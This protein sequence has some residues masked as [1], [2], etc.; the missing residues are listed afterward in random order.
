[1]SP[2]LT[3]THRNRRSRHAAGAC[4]ICRYPALDV[5]EVDLDGVLRLISCPRCEHSRTESPE[6]VRAVVL[7]RFA[8]AA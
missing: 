1:M 6:L 5:D 3:S 4:P 2:D 7:R 8:E